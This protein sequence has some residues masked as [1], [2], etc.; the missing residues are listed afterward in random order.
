MP[1]HE[2]Q[3]R[4][5]IKRMSPAQHYNAVRRLLE[6]HILACPTSPERDALTEANIMLLAGEPK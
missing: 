6:L 2:A 1:A 4:D 3:Y 5:M